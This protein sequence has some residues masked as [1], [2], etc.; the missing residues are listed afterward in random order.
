MMKRYKVVNKTRFCI[1]ITLSFVL[2]FGLISLIFSKERA[3]S[4]VH[5]VKYF[6]VEVVE[7]DTLWTIVSR[8]ITE[9]DN[10]QKLIYDIKKF[11]GMD[12]SYIYPGDII[13]IPTSYK[14][15]KAKGGLS[16]FYLSY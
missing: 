11:N 15:K 8:H 2:I 16:F 12:S 6:E 4:S 5:E 1:F 13:K 3:Y 10:M 9:R 14:W 7:G